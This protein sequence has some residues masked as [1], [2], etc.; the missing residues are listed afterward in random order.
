MLHENYAATRPPRVES[1]KAQNFATIIY[2][3]IYIYNIHIYIYIIYIYIY[4]Y[5]VAYSFSRPLGSVEHSWKCLPILEVR[6]KR[7]RGLRNSDV[8]PGTGAKSQA[9][10]LADVYR[11]AVVPLS[12][13]S[14][15]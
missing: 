10:L 1:I 15:H 8:V 7:A 12:E 3:Y 13:H 6:I 5:I 2:I 11:V 14:E 9:S 4:I